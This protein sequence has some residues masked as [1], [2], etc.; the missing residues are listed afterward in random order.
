MTPEQA[1]KLVPDD[2]PKRPTCLNH[3]VIS[4]RSRFEQFR[5]KDVLDRAIREGRAVPFTPEDHPGRWE[6]LNN[7]GSHSIL[8]SMTVLFYHIDQVIT[9]MELA[10]TSALHGR[11]QFSRLSIHGNKFMEADFG[12]G[13]F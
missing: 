11:W 12:Q 5:S 13:G 6:F 10:L 1:V 3:L 7:L 8:N 9:R 2:H 4:L